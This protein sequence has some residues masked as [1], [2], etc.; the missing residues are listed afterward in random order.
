MFWCKRKNERFLERLCNFVS[1][2]ELFLTCSLGVRRS[3]FLPV[4]E[5]RAGVCAESAE[6]ESQTSNNT[7][8]VSGSVGRRGF[9]ALK[10]AGKWKL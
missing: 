6:T 1:D 5:G 4:P 3:V 10:E 9:D 2:R 7:K 8:I